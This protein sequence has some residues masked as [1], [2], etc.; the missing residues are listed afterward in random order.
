MHRWTLWHG[1]WVWL[2]V[3]QRTEVKQTA[4]KQ[5]FRSKSKTIWTY[6]LVSGHWLPRTSNRKARIDFL[7]NL[8]PVE[9]DSQ[10]RTWAGKALDVKRA[11]A[12]ASRC[13]TRVCRGFITAAQLLLCCPAIC[14]VLSRTWQRCSIAERTPSTG[15]RAAGGSCNYC[16]SIL[17]VSTAVS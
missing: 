8:C 11:H 9:T 14:H 6:K 10:W 15:K 5:P 12:S 17:L 7:V 13:F 2:Q 3:Q 16:T 4:N 1:C